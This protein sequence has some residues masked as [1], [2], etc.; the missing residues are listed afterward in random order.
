MA[1]KIV[2]RSGWDRLRYALSF[3]LILLTLCTLIIATILQRELLDIGLMGVAMSLLALGCNYVYNYV[4]DRWDAR[5]GRIPSERSM[6]RRVLH[7]LGFEL[8]LVTLTLPLMMWWLEL[9][10]IEA[11]IMDLGM[12]A[13]VVVYTFLFGLAYDWLF[14]VKQPDAMEDSALSASLTG[15]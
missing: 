11:L 7:A 8:S 13:G 14:P 9:G 4:F 2:M 6:P 3:E 12:M 5:C 1:T 10:F 15:H